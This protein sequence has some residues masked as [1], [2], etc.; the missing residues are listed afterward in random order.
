M[1]SRRG[2]GHIGGGSQHVMRR[3]RE[4][5]I[6]AVP[7]RRQAL[8]ALGSNRG[9]RSL[10]YISPTK[11]SDDWRALHLD[12]SS[13]LGLWKQVVKEF[14]RDRIDSRYLQPIAC[15]QQLGNQE[16]EGF[17]MVTIQCALIEFLESTMQGK[18]YRYAPT[19]NLGPF[20]YNR[21]G[22][23]FRS[24]L[25]NRHPFSGTFTAT[26]AEDFYANVRCALL[27]EAQTKNGWYIRAASDN[28]IVDVQTKV[29]FRDNFH[30]ALL[31]LIETYEQ[32]VLESVALK[33]AFIRKFDHLANA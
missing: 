6:A 7:T 27:H 29:L 22:A 1:P 20:E 5:G 11:T 30:S 28:V 19:Q 26:L 4:P 16:G 21:S 25:L 15:I 33:E 9:A 8:P 23:V 31:D 13:P 24:F 18:R 3:R 10:M 32:G 12:A 14:F 17:A 2:V